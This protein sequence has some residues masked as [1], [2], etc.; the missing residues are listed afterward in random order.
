MAGGA[1]FVNTYTHE[2]LVGLTSQTSTNDLTAYYEYDAL[3]RLRII[4]DQDRNIVKNYWYNFL[5][6]PVQY[7]P[8]WVNTGTTNC[9]MGTA[10]PTGE[11][12]VE[13]RDTNSLSPT[14]NQTRWI[15][16]GND[17]SDC[18][19]CT[20]RNRKWLNNGCETGELEEV[21]TGLGNGE[22][23]IQ[24]WY[25]FSDGSRR[26]VSTYRGAC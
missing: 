9:L 24:Q 14:Y 23:I 19:T 3:Q 25:R 6:P 12:Q 4:R 17:P 18:P 2:P 7:Q 26:L 22:C 1:Y 10:G 13:Q 15:S 16:G 5:I 11:K 21:I 8:N 20:G